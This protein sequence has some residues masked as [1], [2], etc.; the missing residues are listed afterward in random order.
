MSGVRRPDVATH[1]LSVTG[2]GGLHAGRASQATKKC[3]EPDTVNALFSGGH[4]GL[5]PSC[6]G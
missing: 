6:Q 2:Q 4:R 5:F 1:V 3:F